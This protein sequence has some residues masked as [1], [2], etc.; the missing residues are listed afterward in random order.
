MSDLKQDKFRG[1]IN[2]KL[3]ITQGIDHEH[4]DHKINELNIELERLRLIADNSWSWEWL[5]TPDGAFTF[6]SPSCERITGYPA[7]AF[8]ED[9]DLLF[10][11]IHPR[12]VSDFLTHNLTA[13]NKQ[14]HSNIR[15]RIL[16]KTGDIKYIEHS[17]LPLYDNKG[18]YT[19]SRGSNNEINVHNLPESVI[20][21]KERKFRKFF[22][23]MPY[24]VL[25]LT[26]HGIIEELNPQAARILGFLPDKMV[27]LS[28]ND[29]PW[30][31]INEKGEELGKNE[32]PVNSTLNTG[33]KSE[34]I[35]GI[36]GKDQVK[37]VWLNILVTPLNDDET[38]TL[39]GAFAI[40][41]DVTVEHELKISQEAANREA[42]NYSQNLEDKIRD[43][44]IEIVELSNLNQAIVNSM[45]LALISIDKNGIIKGFNK[46][47]EILL[48]YKASEVIEQKSILDFHSPAEIKSLASSM[49]RE[50][51]IEHYP[52][53]SIIKSICD[54]FEGAP[55]EWTYLKHNGNEVPVLLSLSYLKDADGNQTG[56][57]GV[58][59][60]NTVRKSTEELLRW[61]EHLLQ[62]MSDSSPFGFMVTDT[63]TGRILYFNQRFC[64]IWNFT[65]YED[66]IRSHEIS[67]K[68]IITAIRPMIQQSSKF[69]LLDDKKPDFGLTD[70]IRDEVYLTDG[71]TIGI[72][73]T[74][75]TGENEEYEGDFFIFEDISEQKLIEKRLQLQNAAFESVALA[76][77]ITDV[78]GYI[79]WV[80]PAFTNLT[81]YSVEEAIGQHT[82]LL[83]SGL[84]TR[85][86]YDNL[87]STILQGKVWTGEFINRKK[88]GTVY[89]EVE[90]ITPIINDKG[91]VSRFISVKVDITHRIEMESALR[92]SEARWQTALEGSGY[93]IW[94]MNM[95][96]GQVFYSAQY[97]YML[98]Y[99]ETDN[100]TTI[101]DWTRLVHPSDLEGCQAKLNSHFNE[102]T[103]FYSDE[104]RMRCKDGS[105][106]WIH[107]SGKVI[108]WAAKGKPARVIGTHI[109]IDD[110]KRL[111]VSLME[112]IEKER[113]LNE[114][115]SRFVSTASHEFRTPL[116]SILITS[117][118]LLTYWERMENAQIKDKLNKINNQVLHLT[119]IVNDVLH[120]SKIE[121]GKVEFNPVDIDIIEIC[122]QV[123][124][125][126]NSDPKLASKINFISP[127]SSV[128]MKLDSRLIFQ[129]IN[130]LI[131]NS[132]KYTPENPN[133][134][135]EVAR[136]NRELCISLSDNGI[137]IPE[138]DQK[139]L[140][141]PFYR[142]SN[143]TLIQGNGL[144]LSIV[145]ESVVLHGGNITFKSYPG[146]GTTFY[147]TF[148]DSLIK[149]YE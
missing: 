14:V 64:E 88:D 87:W 112:S 74:R 26:E 71:R 41:Q 77:I 124:E 134:R 117:D 45:G 75:I 140:F 19:G 78:S 82:S 129:V 143:T 12:D 106:K 84:M 103:E 86:F 122:R 123:I 149:S 148:P 79:M 110:R 139:H 20:S 108:E 85:E 141:K 67:Y 38:G 42:L 11:I 5:Q 126:F 21:D 4:Y 46:E 81:G 39:H 91:E 63:G 61:N 29:F 13:R 9:P 128:I 15:F 1:K 40:F 105:F 97:K 73:L 2:E 55:L 23:N 135:L 130:N 54:R 95:L 28:I 35:V 30:I 31:L 132:I 111:E 89:Y 50:T 120:L 116:S 7:S 18:E 104:Y 131:S 60:D 119:K 72:F 98:G 48:G 125:S 57:L 51:G 127:Y 118:S 59:F 47:A 68:D 58:A 133:I 142:A 145:R 76:V 3:L 49:S 121:E 37:I 32:F 90:T 80:N 17:C 66:K 144:G 107:D 6:V 56:Y 101:E 113:E 138:S 70:V 27:G 24:G 114:L 115:K 109:D 96:T 99:D 16:T 22:M 146:Q 94:D 93:G 102:E 137:G 36:T 34:G 136:K 100:W 83:K 10:K 25:F 62:L 8:L 92:V 69:R 33:R 65:G 52:D 44:L 147:I 43:R 53:V